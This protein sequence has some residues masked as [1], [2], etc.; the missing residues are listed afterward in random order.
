MVRVCS[1]CKELS[2]QVAAPFCIPTSNE[3]EALL[4]RLH[5]SLLSLGHCHRGGWS[6]VTVSVSTRFD[7]GCVTWAL[8]PCLI[9]YLSSFMRCLLW[10]LHHF[11]NPLAWVF[12]VVHLEQESFIR[13]DFLQIF[14][15][16]RW[17][18]SSWNGLLAAYSLFIFMKS[19]LH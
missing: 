19:N 5:L 11:L 18:S 6:F 16:I 12:R 2:S 15:L 10:Y 14:S 3:W 8:F 4:L 1:A 17:L 7:Q 9:C 13:Q